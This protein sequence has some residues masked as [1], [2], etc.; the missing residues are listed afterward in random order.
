MQLLFVFLPF[1]SALLQEIN[2]LSSS[3][4]T[5]L[6]FFWMALV[7]RLAIQNL[8]YDNYLGFAKKI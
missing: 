2:I 4:L 1:P 6:P 8:K 5:D 3:S 7:L